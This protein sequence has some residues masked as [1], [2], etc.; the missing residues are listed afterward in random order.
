MRVRVKSCGRIRSKVICVGRAS[1]NDQDDAKRKNAL[2]AATRPSTSQHDQNDNDEDG[3][4]LL[5]II[6]KNKMKKKN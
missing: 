3:I 4:C 2:S 6:S 1:S 5:F